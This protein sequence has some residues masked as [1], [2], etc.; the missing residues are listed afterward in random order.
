VSPEGRPVRC[1]GW[2]MNEILEHR[3]AGNGHPAPNYF[4]EI[5][6]HVDGTPRICELVEHFVESIEVKEAWIGPAALSLTPRGWRR[7]PS[8]RCWKWSRRRISWQISRSA[9]AK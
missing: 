5:I 9:S 1:G 6:P 7:L 4:L 3:S 8:C 2:A